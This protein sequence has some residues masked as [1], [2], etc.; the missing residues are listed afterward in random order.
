MP[1]NKKMYVNYIFQD[2]K[3]NGSKGKMVMVLFRCANYATKN[4]VYRFI[5]FPYLLWYR[6]TVEWFMG[7]ELPWETRVGKRL[8]L[9]HGQSLVVHKSTIIGDDCTLR[10]ST[11]IGNKMLPDGTYSASPIL[12]NNVDV[13]SNA[14][15]IGGIVVKDNVKIGSGAVV[16]KNVPGNSTVVGNPGIVIQRE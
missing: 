8:R 2:W 10:H 9:Y 11:T 13:G 16:I 1:E 4:N 5:A 6:L 12:G 7:I 15:I 14:C 3:V